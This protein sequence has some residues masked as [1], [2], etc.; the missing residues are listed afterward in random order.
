MKQGGQRVKSVIIYLNDNFKGA[1]TEFPEMKITVTPEKGKMIIWNNLD[2]RE[3]VNPDSIHAWLPVTDGTKYI[4]VV[5]VR[6][7]RFINL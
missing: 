3:K 5:W 1:C 6:E 7:G 2:R 4:L